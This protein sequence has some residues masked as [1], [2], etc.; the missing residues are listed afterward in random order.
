MPEGESS[1]YEY[2]EIEDKVSVEYEKRRSQ[3]STLEVPSVVNL[4][5]K[6]A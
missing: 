4:E 2:Q 6:N 1:P 3:K 5:F